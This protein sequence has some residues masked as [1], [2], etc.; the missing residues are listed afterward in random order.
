VLD[1]DPALPSKRGNGTAQPSLAHLYCGQTVGWIKM[2]LGTEVGLGPGHIVLDRDPASCPQKGHSHPI[3]ARV[4]C[5]QMAGLV[6]MPLGS[7]Y[8]GRPRPRRL[9]VRRGPRSAERERGHSITQFW[10]KSIAVKGWMDQD[11]TWSEGT[12]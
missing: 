1:G 6:K 11:T 8:G 10:P 7:W 5:G 9:C 2:K 4:C 12:P 3:F